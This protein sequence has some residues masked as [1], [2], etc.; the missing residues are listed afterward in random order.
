MTTFLRAEYSSGKAPWQD[1]P[2]I[3]DESLVHL[4][5]FWDQGIHS[6]MRYNNELYALFQSYPI[7]ERLKACA[8]ACEHTEKGVNVCVTASKTTYSVWL[9]LRR[10]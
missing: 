8:I 3:I 2:P 1:L 5:K 4:F 9:N 7:Q 10:P 6:G